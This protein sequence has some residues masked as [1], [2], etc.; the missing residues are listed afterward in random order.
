MR[1]FSE[2]NA[3]YTYRRRT[4]PVENEVSWPP[5]GWGFSEQLIKSL[6]NKCYNYKLRERTSLA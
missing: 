6:V 4:R 3:L 2:L 1:F 5:A